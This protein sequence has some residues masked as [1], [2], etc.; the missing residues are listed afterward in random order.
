MRRIIDVTGIIEEGMWKYDDPFPKINILPLPPVPWVNVPVYCEIFD[1]L[2]SQTG[3]YLETPAHFYGNDNP[4]TY[5][6]IDVPIEKLVDAPCIVLDMGIWEMDPAVGRRGITVDDIEKC[7]NVSEIKEG[8]ALLFSTGWGQY[9]KH[10]NYLEYSPFITREA[11][12]WFISKKPFIFGGDIP[13][14]ENLE[15]PEGFFPD[16]YAADILMIAPLV[17]LEE[18]KAPRCR[19]TVLPLKVP[20]TS[21][22]P[23][24][25]IITVD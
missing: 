13:R 7:T 14:W 24:R 10:P 18:V 25:A 9:W 6:L 5:L 23:S 11:M 16:F 8:D 22:A 19:L 2:H 1:G 3:T 15:K 21:C 17:K 12:D 4:C 20:R